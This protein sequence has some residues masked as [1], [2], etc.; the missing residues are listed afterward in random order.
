VQ[1][2]ERAKQQ[3]QLAAKEFQRLEGNRILGTAI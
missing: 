1:L 3:H 2:I